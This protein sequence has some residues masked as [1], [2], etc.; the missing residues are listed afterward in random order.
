MRLE[1]IRIKNFRSFKD[2]TIEFDPYTC[3]VGPNG[4]GKS[5]ILTA[6]NLFF[7]NTASPTNVVTLCDED[8][9]HKGT[10]EPAMVTLTFKDLSAD[11]QDKLKHY[12]RQSRLVVSAKAVWNAS[13]KS[14]EVIQYGIRN[15]MKAFTEYFEAADAGEAAATLKTI[16]EKLQG[17]FPDLP[18]ATSGPTRLTTLRAYEEAHPELCEQLESS[19][20]FFG[21][22]KGSLLGKY[23]QWVYIPAVKDASSEQQD[24]SK[25]ALKEL[26]DRTVR[27]KVNFK[28]PISELKKR[29]EDE[30]RLIIEANKDSL[31]A[32]EARMHGRLKEWASPSAMLKLAWFF[33]DEKSVIVNEPY[34]KATIGEDKFIGE[35]ARLGHGMQRSFLISVLHELATVNSVDGPTLLLGFE[36]PE[37]YQHPPQAQHMSGV[38]EDLANSETT[39]TQVVIST[40]SPHFVSSKGF[41]NVRVVR[42]EPEGKCSEVAATTYAKIEDLI[43][44]AMN[45]KPDLP[46][47]TMASIEQI[48]QPSQKEL[49]FTRLAVLVEGPEDVGFIATHMVLNGQWN[50][51]RRLGCHFIVCG[52]KT[53]LSRPLVIANEL[54]I[55]TFVIFDADSDRKN[56][57]EQIRANNCILNLLGIEKFDP[58]PKHTVTYDSCIVWGTRIADIIRDEATKEV[59]DSVHEQVRKKQGF[60]GTSDKN[61]MFNAAILAELHDRKFTSDSLTHLCTQLLSYAERTQPKPEEV[62]EQTIEL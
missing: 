47:A 40:H 32:I 30:Y 38:L 4:A 48:M 34:A 43:A 14:A 53:N 6:L 17:Q 29:T 1:K 27:S 52:G 18:K 15:V 31:A 36:E 2:E 55:R 57:D 12:Y 42:K 22:S 3:L 23:V 8:F 5:T 45:D 56:K 19:D 25:C 16:Y 54:C 20:Q 61:K 26:L 7:R 35:V 37:L 9:H 33:D 51:F 10:T 46:T 41:E 44:K 60:G 58:L 24:T 11:A 21:F 49:Y 50:E 39:N 13:T 28:D 62:L 59:W